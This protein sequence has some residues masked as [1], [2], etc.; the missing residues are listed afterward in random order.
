[1]SFG[2]FQL[3]GSQEIVFE[4]I[5]PD[6]YTC[7]STAPTTPPPA[8]EGGFMNVKGLG[9]DLHGPHGSGS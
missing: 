5:D 3:S 2:D 9:S 6:S 8:G 7:T 1:L 4:L